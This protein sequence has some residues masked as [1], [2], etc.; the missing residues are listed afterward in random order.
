MTCRGQLPALRYDEEL[1]TNNRTNRRR[2]TTP[3]FFNGISLTGAKPDFFDRNIIYR[4]QENFDGPRL[5][6]KKL[7]ARIQELL[8][9]ALGEILR[10]FQGR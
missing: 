3:S 4:T 7:V 5:S 1:Y 6:E 10:L 8:P 9:Y 2:Y